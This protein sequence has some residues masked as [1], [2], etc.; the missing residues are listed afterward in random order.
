M[1]YADE[2]QAVSVDEALIDVTNAVAARE[3]AP[4]EA[5]DSAAVPEADEELEAEP[6]DAVDEG[7]ED[8]SMLDRPRPRQRDAAMEI[9]QKIR[10]DIRKE[11]GCEGKCI[12]DSG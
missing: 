9:A 3:A 11:T 7:M 2:L 1:G 4:E 8:R 6:L 12:P 10:D 5:E